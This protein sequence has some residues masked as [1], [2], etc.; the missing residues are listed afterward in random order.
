MRRK[1]L[2]AA[3]ISAMMITSFT[4]CGNDTTIT[5]SESKETA[6]ISTDSKSESVV[7]SSSSLESVD[8]I[9]SITA[10]YPKSNNIINEI[11][12]NTE[13]I[14]DETILNEW[15]PD[16]KN[17][18]KLLAKTIIEDYNSSNFTEEMEEICLADGVCTDD[19]SRTYKNIPYVLEHYAFDFTVTD[20]DY[21]IIDFSKSVSNDITSYQASIVFT[22]NVHGKS[23]SREENDYKIYMAG[24]LIKTEDTNGFI[25]GKINSDVVLLDAEG[26]SVSRESKGSYRVEGD[27]ATSINYFASF[28]D[29]SDEEDE[30]EQPLVV[31]GTSEEPKNTEGV[32]GY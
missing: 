13:D 14:S 31:Y 24:I 6:S 18:T 10:E 3:I 27:N 5:N 9:D 12:N 28:E 2:T 20:I 16:V 8:D 22:V 23:A 15:L 7:T 17:K 11:H 21:N 32:L 26:Y 29:E 25:F 1:I 19:P 30:S 4:G